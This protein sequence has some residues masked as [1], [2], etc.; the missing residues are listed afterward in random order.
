MRIL[1]VD[2][3]RNTRLALTAALES[4]GHEVRDAQNGAIALNMLRKE[5]FD[6]LMLLGPEVPAPVPAPV[7]E[8]VLYAE[9]ALD[10]ADPMGSDGRF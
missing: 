10:P 9:P 5:A 1:I 4:M 3:E 2:D 7:P 6:V 8:P